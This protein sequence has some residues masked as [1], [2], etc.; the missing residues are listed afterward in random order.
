MGCFQPRDASAHTSYLIVLLK[1]GPGFLPGR[2]TI[3]Q[4]G[5]GRSTGLAAFFS[6][7]KHPSRAKEPR[8]IRTAF[9]ASTVFARF[10]QGFFGWRF[11]EQSLDKETPNRTLDGILKRFHGVPRR[12]AEGIRVLKGPPGRG[13]EVALRAQGHGAGEIR[14]APGRSRNGSPA[15]RRG[16]E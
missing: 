6:C 9:R 10:F 14:Q 5:S 4:E 7:R 8:I 16:F 12:G 11:F 1:S 15:F 13:P 3:I 2:P